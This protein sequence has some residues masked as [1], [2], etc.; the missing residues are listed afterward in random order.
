MMLGWFHNQPWIDGYG[1]NTQKGD[2]GCL[3]SEKNN[4]GSFTKV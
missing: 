2:F 4:V 3:F 1:W